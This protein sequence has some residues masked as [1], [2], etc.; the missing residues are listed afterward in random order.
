[1]IKYL[2]IVLFF[3]LVFP[4]STYAQHSAAIQSLLREPASLFDLGMYRLNEALKNGSIYYDPEFNERKLS[5][6]V[7]YYP[8]DNQVIIFASDGNIKNG[9][10]NFTQ[11]KTWGREAIRAIRVEFGIDSESGTIFSSDKC[12][13]LYSYFIH[14]DNTD[15]D[16]AKNL[17]K[18]LDGITQIRASIGITGTKNYEYC[19][20]PLVSKEIHFKDMILDK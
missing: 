15:W 7:T 10:G 5:I 2:K 16:R 6:G 8:A 19:S 3:L 9:A 13:T 17:G 20:G 11:A 12:S 1:M 4:S 18:E 14:Y